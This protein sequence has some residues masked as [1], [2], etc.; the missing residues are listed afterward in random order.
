M[1]LIDKLKEKWERNYSESDTPLDEYM[2]FIKYLKSL[3][4]LAKV[5]NE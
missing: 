5:S 3:I 4:K 2:G 1:S